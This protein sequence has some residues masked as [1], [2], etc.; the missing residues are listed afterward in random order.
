MSKVRSP[1]RHVGLGFGGDVVARLSMMRRRNGDRGA[2]VVEFALIMP[3]FLLLIFGVIQ[4]GMYFW[5]MQAGA[6]AVGEA[7]RRMSVGD[8]QS[9]TEVQNLLKTRLGSATTATAGS[10]ITVAT[11]YTM[12][13]GST[14]SGSPGQIGGTVQL[15]ATFSTVD[16]HFPFIPVPGGATVTRSATARIEDITAITG[17]CS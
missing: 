8:C 14:P 12:A 15:T 17:G 11:S 3:I 2:V 7:T 5:S 16:L 9:S 4:Y 10:G 13:D 6:N 1:D